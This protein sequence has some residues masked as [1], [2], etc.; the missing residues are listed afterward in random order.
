MLN[1]KDKKVDSR[2]NKQADDESYLLIYPKKVKE[3]VSRSINTLGFLDKDTPDDSSK[4][5]MDDEKSSTIEKLD[6]IS[7]K[8][9]NLKSD[10]KE[11]LDNLPYTLDYNNKAKE[12]KNNMAHGSEYFYLSGKVPESKLGDFE[13]LGKKYPNT[14]ISTKYESQD[15]GPYIFTIYSKG[16]TKGLFFNLVGGCSLTSETSLLLI[17]VFLC[18]LSSF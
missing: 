9:E 10:N 14:L 11:I 16:F 6:E 4:N 18:L 17:S 13:K 3:D 15:G 7:K 1:N 5:S 2:S 12:L 8:T